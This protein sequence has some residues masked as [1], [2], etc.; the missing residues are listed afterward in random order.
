MYNKFSKYF[1]DTIIHLLWYSGVQN[2]VG[3]QFSNPIGVV[4]VDADAKEQIFP[5]LNTVQQHV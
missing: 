3:I 5:M 4:N 1:I 2:G